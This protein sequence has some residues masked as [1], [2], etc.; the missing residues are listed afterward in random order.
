MLLIKESFYGMY[1][2]PQ[3]KHVLKTNLQEIGT[4]E[5]AVV[6]M[7]KEFACIVCLK[8]TSNAATIQNGKLAVGFVSL[9]HLGY[10]MDMI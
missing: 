6:D 9:Q 3:I 1:V 10:D 2:C 8:Q 7:I 5:V 4:H